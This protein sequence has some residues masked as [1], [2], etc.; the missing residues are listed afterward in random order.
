MVLINENPINRGYNAKIISMI[1]MG[2]IYIWSISRYTDNLQLGGK[3]W[4]LQMKFQS[5]ELQSN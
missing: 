3:V 1:S 5:H 4:N 2:G